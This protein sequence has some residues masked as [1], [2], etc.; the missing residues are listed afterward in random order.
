MDQIAQ[1]PNAS[2]QMECSGIFH[3]DETSSHFISDFNESDNASTN[4]ISEHYEISSGIPFL[5][6]Q[7]AQ[8][9]LM[10]PVAPNDAS[11][12]IY[13]NKRS[14]EFLLKDHIEPRG[15]SRSVA[16]FGNQHRQSSATLPRSANWVQDIDSRSAQAMIY[17]A[18]W[19]TTSQIN[20]QRN[21][22]VSPTHI[23]E[24]TGQEYQ[25]KST[26]LPVAVQHNPM[27]I[28]EP[29]S[30]PG[31]QQ[32]FGQRNVLRNQIS[33][34]PNASSQMNCSSISR[35][36]ETSSQFISDCNESINASTNLIWRYHQTS[37][38]IPILA[39]QNAHY[40]PMD[41]VP[42]T[43]A[44]GPIHSNKCPK[45]FLPKDYLEPSDRSRSHARP[46]V[47][48]NFENQHRQSSATLPRSSS[49]DGAQDIDLRAQQ[50]LYEEWSPTMNQTHSSWQYGILPNMHQR[51]D[52]EETAAAEIPSPYGIEKSE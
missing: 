43:D 19:P 28:A 29:C 50:T 49:G 11:G 23:K 37:S 18:R 45:E 8:Y 9:N 2:S 1:R 13:S 4:R 42:P 35:M 5:A 39:D 21:K 22:A 47:C 52:R 25:Y 3:T 6:D 27:P 7:D 41:P 40:N 24:P 31:F 46:Y 10:D 33:H 14:K 32:T 36:G 17:E 30:L 15:R 34:Y 16:H 48:K 12:P 44:S 20:F 51:T 38:G 26:H